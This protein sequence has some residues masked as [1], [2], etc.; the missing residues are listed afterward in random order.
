VAQDA[1]G[2]FVD[3]LTQRTAGA[4]AAANVVERDYRI[5]GKPMRLR[6]AGD[7]LVD[8]VTAALAHGRVE[9]GAEPE[10]VVD[11]WDSESIGQP[12]LRPAWPADAYIQHGAVAG[13]FDDDLQVMFSHGSG[14]ITMVLPHSGRAIFWLS[15]AKRFTDVDSG[16]PLRTLLHLWLCRS[17]LQLQH[18]AALGN[19]DGCVLVVG[20]GGAGKSST[21]LA[22]LDADFGHIA[23][24][25]CVLEPGDPP[26]V[27][28]LY[29]SI[30]LKPDAIERVG[31][32]QRLIAN[33]DRAPDE[34]AIVFLAQHRPERL[35]LD[36][37]VKAIAVP[38]IT[39]RPESRVAGRVSGARALRELAP[40]TIFQLPGYGE[41]S[42]RSMGDVVR[43]VPS[44]ALE[45]G[46]DP[47][48]VAGALR[49]LLFR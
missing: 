26:R 2:A 18:S 8:R 17:G 49:E 29:S 33:P 44:Y 14:A 5:A 20:A 3:E 31:L 41:R 1:R 27:H 42:V 40:S 13:F 25:Y 43:A 21:A 37:P 46:T 4:L 6:F 9:G 23:D 30:K 47:S 16:S 22:C 34:K 32:D 12:P 11:L 48:Q 35:V 10:L 45:V 39:G 15:S 36:A 7:A 19:P 24:D 38:V 28:M